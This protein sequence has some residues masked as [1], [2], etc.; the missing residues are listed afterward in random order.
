MNIAN[1]KKRHSQTNKW[2]MFFFDA[3]ESLS[4]MLGIFIFSPIS[5]GLV[6]SGILPSQFL[7]LDMQQV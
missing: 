3:C 7:H 6:M 4:L 1:T 2:E 5:P